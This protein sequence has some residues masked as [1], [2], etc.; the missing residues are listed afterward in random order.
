MPT[1]REYLKYQQ[2]GALVTTGA[3]SGKAEVGY[4][5][6]RQ[7]S[8]AI[9]SS[10][11]AATNTAET[12]LGVVEFKSK[13]KSVKLT[14]PTTNIAAGTDY[15][16]VKVY[17][18]T[19]AGASQTLIAQYNTATGAQGAV[20][21]RVPADFAVIA[22]SDSTLDAESLVTFEVIKGASGKAIDQYSMLDFVFE[23]V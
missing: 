6:S 3:A 20:T 5:H 10:A 12:P 17:K 14:V 1:D 19:A 4:A 21:L 18:R 8:F 9:F 16:H 11:N 23:E 7:R 15:A 13:L 22:N 2:A